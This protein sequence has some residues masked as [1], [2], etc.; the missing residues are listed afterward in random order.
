MLINSAGSK[1]LPASW[2]VYPCHNFAANTYFFQDIFGK[3][4]KSRFRHGIFLICSYHSISS[5][6]SKSNLKSSTLQLYFFASS[7]NSIY[8]SR[9]SRPRSAIRLAIFDKFFTRFSFFIFKNWLL[10]ISKYWAMYP[11]T[12]TYLPFIMFSIL[13]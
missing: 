5:G 3:R 2:A 7:I 1:I 6:K 8:N 9:Y 10:R 12:Y 4:H 13:A 11:F